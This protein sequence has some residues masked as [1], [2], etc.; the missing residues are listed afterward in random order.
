MLRVKLSVA[1]KAL[2]QDIR[3]AIHMAME[4]GV[5]GVQ[6]DLR[7]EVI[8]AQYGETARRQLLHY[9]NERG[10]QVASACFPLRGP[11][12]AKDRLGER[13]SALNEAIEFAGKLKTR[14]LVIRAGRIPDAEEQSDEWSTLQSILSELAAAGNRNGV[15]LNL[16]PCGES[17]GQT[18]ALVESIK[19]GPM[20]VD[21]DL[22]AWIMNRQSIVTQIRELHDLIGH[23]EMR[24]AIRDVDG[25]GRE[26]PVGQG[27]VDWQELFAL[28]HETEFTGWLNVDRQGNSVQG[29]ETLSAICFLQKFLPA[30]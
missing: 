25:R 28:I 24:D 12:A 3:R 11:L 23:Y 18:R 19:T 7:Y 6:V 30:V 13:L 14:T 1:I 21:A 10:L 16:V 26:V 29:T 5:H 17:V 8:P 27:E 2:S 15:T 20:C 22:A 9:L 4:A